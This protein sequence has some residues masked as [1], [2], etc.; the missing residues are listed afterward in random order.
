MLSGRRWRAAILVLTILL[1]APGFARDRLR[2]GAVAEAAALSLPL[3]SSQTRKGFVTARTARSMMV[4]EG[5]STTQVIVTEKTE[6][7]GQRSS[8]ASVA[9]G[10]VVR[11]DGSMTVDRHLLAHRVDVI[12]AADSMPTARRARTRN[13]NSLTSVLLNGGITVLLP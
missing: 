12:L 1:A 7:A 9:I 4:L 8:F 3:Q 2:S 5:S 10:D 6:I 13:V 11:V